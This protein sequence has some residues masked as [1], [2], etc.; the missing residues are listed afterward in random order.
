MLKYYIHR[1]NMEVKTGYNLGKLINEKSDTLSEP[2]KC[3]G[4][5]TFIEEEDGRKRN[6]P[7][8]FMKLK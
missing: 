1:R 7:T 3:N 8:P 4:F 6:Y 5:G 2:E